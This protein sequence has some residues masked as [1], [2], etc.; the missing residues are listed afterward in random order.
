[1]FVVEGKAILASKTKPGVNTMVYQVR[2]FVATEIVTF[3]LNFL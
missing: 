3:F 2:L 1:M